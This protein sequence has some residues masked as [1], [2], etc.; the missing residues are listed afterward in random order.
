M[1]D[2]FTSAHCSLPYHM[3]NDCREPNS[4][5]QFEKH[6]CHVPKGGQTG[7]H[8]HY[9][10]QLTVF[11]G[12]REVVWWYHLA[13]IAKLAHVGQYFYFHGFKRFADFFFIISMFHV[14]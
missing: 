10:G 8:G 6:N 7:R 12:R 5:P 14:K 1:S 9:F 3:M 4:P 11:L 2:E 13:G